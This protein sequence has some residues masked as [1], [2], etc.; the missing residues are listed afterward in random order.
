MKY[1]WLPLLLFVAGWQACTYDTLPESEVTCTDQILY[2]AHIKPIIETKCT[3][4]GCH[5]GTGAGL[6]NFYEF[7]NLQERAQLVKQLT[8]SREMPRVGRLTRAQIDSIAC[9]V[10]NGALEN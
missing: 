8:S 5:N 3:L 6:P 1:S 10:D 9:W 4:D 7:E 2:S